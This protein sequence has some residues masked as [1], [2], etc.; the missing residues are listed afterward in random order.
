MPFSFLSYNAH[1]IVTSFRDK[2]L[3]G[4]RVDGPVGRRF[5]RGLSLTRP[6]AVRVVVGRLMDKPLWGLRVLKSDGAVAPRV[7]KF[8]SGYAAEGCGGRL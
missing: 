8:D 6:A 3:W 7:L 1:S 5:L 2:P 4:L